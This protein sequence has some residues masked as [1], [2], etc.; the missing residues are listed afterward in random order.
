M[1]VTDATARLPVERVAA[2]AIAGW[3]RRNVRSLLVEPAV[4][5]IA[6][7]APGRREFAPFSR[8]ASANRYV[9]DPSPS[10]ER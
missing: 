10:G 5:D 4:S 3:D 8:Q 9:F 7:V 2:T 6:L 1:T